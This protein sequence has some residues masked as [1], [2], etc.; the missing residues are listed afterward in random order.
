MPIA[1][2]ISTNEFRE[3]MND[4]TNPLELIREGIQNSIDAN[5]SK[6]I[7]IISENDTAQGKSLDI[8]IEDNGHGLLK[9]N[10]SNFFNLGDSTKRNDSTKIGEKGHGTKIYFNSNLV[11]V[12]S[13]YGG[14]KYLTELTEPYR[15][16]F[17]ESPLEY[18]EIIES[19]NTE[20]TTTGTRVIVKGYLKNVSSMPF[21]S[22]AHP[23]VKDYIQWFTAFASIKN[24]FEEVPNE[25]ILY[26]RTFDSAFKQIQDN[27]RIKLNADGFEEIPFGH[28]FPKIEYYKKSDLKELAKQTNTR[29]WEDLFC[30]KLYCKSIHLE[31]IP[32]PINIVIWAVGDKQKRLLNPLIRERVSAYTRAFE[33]KVGERYGFWACKNN[34]PIQKIDEWISGKGT[35]TKFQAFVNFNDFSLTANRSSIENTRTE[36]LNKIKD[37]LDLV[38]DEI[39]TDQSFK[40]WIKIEEMADQERSSK[41]ENDEFIKRIKECKSKKKIL[42]SNIP[43][44]EPRYEGEVAL[45]FSALLKEY[46]AELKF[47]ILDY[48]THKGVDFLIR[49]NKEVPIENDSTIG[50]VE[51]K[52]NLEKGRFNHSFKN[53]RYIVCYNTSGLKIGDIVSDLNYLKLT[54]VKNETGWALADSFAEVG[55]SIQIIILSEFLRKKGLEFS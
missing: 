43:F 45:L 12:E 8:V 42:L 23:A 9:E 2:I 25:P 49:Q 54:V 44:F 37:K 32:N 34:I 7:I 4:F 14:K 24:Q 53:L 30:K 5:A 29:D 27:F 16:I 1:E 55:H 33:Y 17:E 40:D 48:S 36:Y 28:P 35:Y 19:E 6:I 15:K 31:G 38:Y 21:D 18:S 20:Q 41:E 46:P 52:Y 11:R 51:L 3:I 50:Y 26:L 47:E 13:W 39:I 22:F 10:Y